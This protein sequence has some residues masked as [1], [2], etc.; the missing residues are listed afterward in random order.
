MKKKYYYFVAILS[1]GSDIIHVKGTYNTTTNDFPIQEVENHILENCTFT[2][3]SI[4]ISFYKEITE[5]NYKSYNNEQ[6]D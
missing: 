6:Q 4:V 1:R 2:I 5:E 3:D